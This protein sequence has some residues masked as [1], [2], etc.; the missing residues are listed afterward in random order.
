[1][2]TK[3]NKKNRIS[4]LGYFV[5]RM[6]DNGYVVWKMF[7]KY[8]FAD[9]RKWTVL[10]NP[11]NESVFVTCRVNVDGIASN[12]HFDI[13]DSRQSTLKNVTIITES[14]EVLINHLIKSGVTPD[15]QHYKKSDAT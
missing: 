4:T 8:S 9:S 14:L 10:I 7:D 2:Q 6:K 11:G 15:S 5:K 3:K 12:P 13:Y 1:M